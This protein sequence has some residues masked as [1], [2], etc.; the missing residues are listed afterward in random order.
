MDS[1][2]F[3]KRKEADEV[4]LSTRAMLRDNFDDH[5]FQVINP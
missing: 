5:H 4:M 3:A 2:G 1:S